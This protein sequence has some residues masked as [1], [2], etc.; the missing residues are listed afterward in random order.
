MCSR[1]VRLSLVVSL[2]VH[3][4]SLDARAQEEE[5]EGIRRWETPELIKAAQEGDL[6]A[7]E[8]RLN[9]GANVDDL[10]D[11]GETALMVACRKG[12]ADIVTLLLSKKAN[13]NLRAKR[14]YTALILAINED[15][16]E[17]VAAL[18]KAGAD[19]NAGGFGDS[20]LMRAVER[21]NKPIV[22]LLLEQKPDLT[23]GTKRRGNAL[24]V[25]VQGGDAGIVKMLIAAGADVNAKVGRGR[26]ARTAISIAKRK[27]ND[28]IIGIL[29]SAGAKEPRV[30][31]SAGQVVEMARNAS[32]SFRLTELKEALA[33]GADPNAVSTVGGE[34]ALM[35]AAKEGNDEAVQ[36]LLK[37]GA[38]P[39]F[40][41]K[42]GETALHKAAYF[43]AHSEP[44]RRAK[45]TGSKPLVSA[46]AKLLVAA[47]ADVNLQDGRHGKT[48]LLWAVTG[49]D[50]SLVKLLLTPQAALEK[51]DKNGLSALMQAALVGNLAAAKL[52]I[53][54]KADVNHKSRNGTMT[55][56]SL[57]VEKGHNH[58][59]RSVV[60]EMVELLKAAGAKDPS[61]AVAA[62]SPGA[63]GSA[64]VPEW[65]VASWAMSN[66]LTNL[67]KA[68]AAGAN[69]NAVDGLV[70]S[71]GAS[72]GH[73]ALMAAAQY[74]HDEA[75]AVLLKAGADPNR[76]DAN[77]D[78]ALHH[79][80]GGKKSGATAVLVAAG[81]DLNILD[82]NGY[83]ALMRA[84]QSK[85]ENL[86]KLLLTP[87]TD[88]EKT[89][90]WRTALTVAVDSGEV[91][92]VK[93][94]IAAKANLNQVLANDMTALSWA[95]NKGNAAI[96]AALEAAGAKVHD[97]AEIARKI[98]AE[99]IARQVTWEMNE[100]KRTNALG[101]AIPQRQD[102][103][104]RDSPRRPEKSVNQKWRE[105][106][107][108]GQSGCGYR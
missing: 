19:I 106:R 103:S 34:S 97:P 64:A 41:D 32:T 40:R 11:D 84:I 25:A 75:I 29:T 16:P 77:G 1:I 95:K 85:D 104:Y 53:A 36:L 2:C 44:Y 58:A 87:K 37:A 62:A 68:L 66:D 23:R 30:V 107:A 93:L 15:S 35:A 46:A 8:A 51:E 4:A 65:Q 5:G 49:K 13:V 45:P 21:G 94:L 28:E 17:I 108:T 99:N 31:Y 42:D 3:V 98:Q 61:A 14:G 100:R 48:P 92:L 86:V 69:P 12:R 78:T 101:R 90:R 20:P 47:G 55:A 102:D 9:K 22:Q 33:S 91:G 72:A 96:V 24:T 6:A 70:T 71:T 54:A 39:N 82:Q 57:A 80:V 7:V 76:Q 73:T 26:R 67:K 89:N 56:L 79:A 18:L 10:T 63:R 59:P 50:E 52:L 83:T 43:K 60:S 81:A 27:G 105:C 38:N 74:G 88:L